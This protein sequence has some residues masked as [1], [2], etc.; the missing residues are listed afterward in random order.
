[1]QALNPSRRKF[2]NKKLDESFNDQ[3]AQPEVNLKANLLEPVGLAPPCILTPEPSPTIESR[4]G[5]H[6]NHE[7]H[8]AN[9]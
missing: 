8:N 7:I 9:T 1:M 5:F 4:Q 6:F 2:F 3:E